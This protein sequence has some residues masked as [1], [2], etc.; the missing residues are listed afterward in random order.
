MASI[1]CTLFK[2]SVHTSVLKGIHL[3]FLHRVLKFLFLIFLSS[4]YIWSSFLCVMWDR[5]QIS[6]FSLWLNNFPALLIKK[7]PPYP[8]ILDTIFLLS[9]IHTHMG[10]FLSSSLFYR[11]IYLSRYGQPLNWF[12][13]VLISGKTSLSS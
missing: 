4:Y 8:L 6:F 1:F 13:I 10:L 9:K 12:I 2:K 3:H 5:D 7:P 11:P